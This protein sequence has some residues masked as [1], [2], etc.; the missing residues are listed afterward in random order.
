MRAE[1]PC[2]RIMARIVVTSKVPR[3]EWVNTSVT[4]PVAST[5]AD[6]VLLKTRSDIALHNHRVV[7][8]LANKPDEMWWH[9]GA[10]RVERIMHAAIERWCCRPAVEDAHD[11]LAG[12]ISR[13]FV[14]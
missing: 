14:E 2:E 4:S 12:E 5:A 7:A 9:V 8:G 11:E 6:S 1:R 3:V 13:I 10:R